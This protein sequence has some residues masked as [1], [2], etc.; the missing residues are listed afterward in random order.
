MTG[1]HHKQMIPRS[2]LIGAAMVMILSMVLAASA[3]RA[4]LTKA[5]PMPTPIESMAIRFEDRPDGAI[6]VLDAATGHAVSVLP[7]RS[8]GFVRGV[9]RGMFR[10]RKLESKDRQAS[11]LLARH[12]EGRLTLEDPQT[13]RRVELDSFGSTNAAAFAQLLSAGRQAQR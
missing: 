4:R 12:A 5:M 13:G 7:P 3:R 9:L 1:H 6:A 11:F 10:T 8:N 2:V